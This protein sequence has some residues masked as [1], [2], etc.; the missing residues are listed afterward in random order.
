M[1]VGT[2]RTL[3]YQG[4]HTPQLMDQ[5]IPSIKNTILLIFIYN[6]LSLAL[7]VL[8]QPSQNITEM[9]LILADKFYFLK[10]FY[11]YVEKINISDNFTGFLKCY[12]EIQHM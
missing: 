1:Y 2:Y 12:V 11:S 5:L 4:S 3:V 7:Y 9:S 10:F 8:V 6:I